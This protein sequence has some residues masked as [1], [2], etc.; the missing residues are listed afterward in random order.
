MKS[1]YQTP[2]DLMG[3]YPCLVRDWLKNAGVKRIEVKDNEY[4]IWSSLKQLCQVNKNVL[5]HWGWVTHMRV[6]RLTIIGSDNV[7]TPGWRQ[8][9]ICANAGILLIVPLRINF[10]KIL[11]GILTFS[12]TKMRLKAP[13]AKWRPFCFGLNVLTEC[14]FMMLYGVMKRCCS[15]LR[16]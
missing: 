9:I 13:S 8:A 16:Q 5:I 10:S 14:V 1:H 7:L 12:L 6:S 3:Q 11:I 15:W 4:L 2:L